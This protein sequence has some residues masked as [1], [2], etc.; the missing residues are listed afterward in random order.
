MRFTTALIW[1][2]RVAV[3][4]FAAASLLPLVHTG[5]WVIRLFDFPRIQLLVLLF[6]PLLATFAHAVAKG[7]FNLEHLILLLI[8]TAT[9]IWQGSH[10][11]PFTPVWTKELA[12]STESD[13]I[14]LMVANLKV[15]N[16]KHQAVIEVIQA[17][18][19]DVLLLIEIDDKWAEA[20]IPF[21]SAFPH[22]IDV[23]LDEGLGLALWSKLPL[24]SKEVKY[25]VSKRRPSIFATLVLPDRSVI[26]F[27]GV[28]P[29]PPGLDDETEGGR[30]DSRV[31]DAELVLVAKHV[32]AEP[33]LRWIV[34]GDF[35]DVAWSHTTRLFKRLS[36]LR[37]PRV[38]RS[39]L[40]TYHAD[41]PPFR[42]PIDQVFLSE[43]STVGKL[44]RVRLPGSDHFAVLTDLHAAATGSDAAP[45]QQAE[46]EAHEIVEEG[47]E[48]AAERDVQPSGEQ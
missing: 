33:D 46:S 24:E 26:R 10:A 23:I 34:A 17:H 11:L 20:L 22:R 3:I 7:K 14:R 48:D 4:A 6:I 13:G 16:S 39:L 12:D 1:F 38:G 29:T 45:P 27:I 37:D 41:Y 8:I 42:Y 40:N 44:G 2:A 9:A 15:D 43:G 19:P 25:L 32:A 28:H 35:N 21:R 31:R 30:R 5:S 18:D 36:G 47:K